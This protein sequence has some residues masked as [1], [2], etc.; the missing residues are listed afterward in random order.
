MFYSP[1]ALTKR[2]WYRSVAIRVAMLVF[3]FVYL[4]IP[5][6]MTLYTYGW[7]SVVFGY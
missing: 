1:R 2:P 3:I 7:E 6:L 4:G 5:V